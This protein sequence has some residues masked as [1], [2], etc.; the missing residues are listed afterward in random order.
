MLNLVSAIIK[1]EQILGKINDQGILYSD[2]TV[3]WGGGGD[4]WETEC[5]VKVLQDNLINL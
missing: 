4:F 1:S 2:V 3:T 5:M